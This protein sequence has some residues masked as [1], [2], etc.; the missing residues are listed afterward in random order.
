L[1]EVHLILETIQ[2]SDQ[3]SVLATIIHVE[4]SAY[5]K[6]GTSMLFLE[7]GARIGVLSGG[8]LE[9]DLAARVPDILEAGVSCVLS[10]D[11]QSSDP[12]SWG[13]SPGCG[14]VI[15]VAM[16]PVDSNLTKHLITLKNELDRG[17]RVVHFKKI[18]ADRTVADYGFSIGNGIFFGEWKGEY[19]HDLQELTVTSGEIRRSGTQYVPSIRSD[20]FFHTYVPVPR[21][22]VFGAGP[23]ARPLVSFAAA[24]GFRVTVFDWRPELCRREHFPD[25]NALMLGLPEQWTDMISFTPDDYA[26]V[27]THHF[28]KDQQLV[29]LLRERPLRYFGILGSKNRTERLLHGEPV[30]EHI[31]YPVG[32]AIGAEGPMEIA[33]S[34][35]ADLIA[36]YRKNRSRKAVSHESK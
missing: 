36:T 2:R 32:I 1:E 18:G 33:V 16:E 15:H 14:G 3:R 17:S 10:F 35:L 5:R 34:I 27:M 21:L 8:C 30:P 31:R 26:V 22:M 9:S 6:E 23:D 25:A 13:E 19:T 11:M 20:V 24:T 7:N 12:L 29:R 28:E 4:G